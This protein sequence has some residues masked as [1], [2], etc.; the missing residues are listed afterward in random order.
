MTQKKWAIHGLEKAL[1][2]VP[3]EQRAKVTAELEEE[4]RDFDPNA[5]PAERVLPVAPGT[6]ACPTCRGTL[7][8]LGV[9][10]NP[11]GESFCILEC[12]SCDATFC[13]SL[14]APLQ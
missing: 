12:L 14:A 4:L 2:N 10:P 7:E 11:A 1:E 8:E 3:E 5:Q 6:R 13:E 9:I